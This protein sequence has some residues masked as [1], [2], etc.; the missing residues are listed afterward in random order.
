MGK[1]RVMYT[2]GHEFENQPTIACDLS[3]AGKK[4]ISPNKKN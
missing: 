4:M 3:F 1:Q 2:L